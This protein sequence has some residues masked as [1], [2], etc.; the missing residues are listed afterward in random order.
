MCTIL[1]SVIFTPKNKYWLCLCVYF[2]FVL[3]GWGFF[4]F[5]FGFG[6]FFGGYLDTGVSQIKWV[7]DFDD[8]A[9]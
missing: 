4:G 7:I 2:C 9:Y 5:G 8:L 3:F 6:V 1:G